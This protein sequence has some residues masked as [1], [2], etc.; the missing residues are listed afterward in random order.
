MFVEGTIGGTIAVLLCSSEILNTPRP[1]RFCTD[2]YTCFSWYTHYQTLTTNHNLDTTNQIWFTEHLERRLKLFHYPKTIT[3]YRKI[4]QTRAA[5]SWKAT[6][7]ATWVSTGDLFKP[8]AQERLWRSQSSA[9][10]PIWITGLGFG[11]GICE[12]TYALKIVSVSKQ[13]HEFRHSYTLAKVKMILSLM[14]E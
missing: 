5:T 2:V 10:F 14:V 8:V 4:T 6:F 13:V 12:G 1:W 3:L 7:K 11:H 9:L